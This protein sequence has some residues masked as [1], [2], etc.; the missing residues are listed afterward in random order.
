MMEQLQRMH[1]TRTALALGIAV[2][3]VAATPSRPPV[4]QLNPPVTVTVDAALNR[5]PIDPRIYGVAFATPSA[6][7]NL[8]VTLNRWGGNA[9]SRHNWATSTTNR[10]KDWFFENIPDTVA[11]DGSNGES[12]DAFIGPTLA[13][14]AQAVMTIPMMGLLPKDRQVRCGFSIAKYGP[15]NSNDWQWQP[16]C[17]DGRPVGQPNGR[18]LNVNDPADTSA[19]YPTSHQGDWMQHLLDTWG[20]A[21]AGGVRYYAL[22]NEPSLWSFDHWDVHPSGST[23][24]EVWGKMAEYGALIR[25]KD[26]GALITGIEEWGWSGYFSSGLDQENGDGADRAA[27]G[28]ADYGEWLLQ[29]AR[30]HE[31]TNGQRI[32]DIAS[33]HFY[34]QSG[35]FSNDVSAAMQERRNRS[36]RSLWDTTYV[37]ES[38]IGGTGIDG[39]KVRLIPRLREWVN[40]NYPGTLIGIT[41]YNWGAESH[42]NGATAQADILGIFGREGLDVGIRWVSPPDGTPAFNAFRMYR[43]YDGLQSRF[44]DVSVSATGTDP[45]QIST[46]AALRSSDRK[47]TIMIVAKNLTDS[48]PVT[49]NLQN[50]TPTG[51]AERWQL[52][53]ANVITH[54][55]PD[56]PLGPITVPAQSITLL[57]I[58]GTFLDA[59]ASLTATATSTSA[60]ALSWPAVAGASGYDIYGS[61]MGGAFTL[62]GSS[63]TAGFSDNGLAAGTTYLYR[64]RATAPGAA[65][66]FSPVDAATTIVFTDDPLNAGTVAKALHIAELRNA[67]HAMR[68]AAGLASQAFTD[69]PVTFGTTIK[70]VHIAELRRAL[71]Q[72]RATIGLPHLVYTDRAVVPQATLLKRSH[73]TDLRTAV[74]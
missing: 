1:V 27:H 43:N 24:D 21:N 54:V 74:K 4:P 2:F 49:V 15:Q 47:L 46:F 60:A 40:R 61:S 68:L 57:V 70:A 36:T 71:N 45:D 55:M 48:T 8:G 67:V 44:G 53:A 3:A 66:G 41:E 10:A 56:A 39:G 14:G 28:N 37:D 33:L 29:Q 7:A 9:V 19:V 52:D 20:T 31:E 22:D 34:P 17:G 59:P 65:S 11:G 12:A 69:N 32:L 26:P 25:A 64:V 58:P 18:I 73:L 38:W 42:I 63:G 30:I 35:E 51:N 23:Y 5:H 50:F 62:V 72:A 13:A 6:L 16:D